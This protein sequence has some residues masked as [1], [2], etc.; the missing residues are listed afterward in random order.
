M[1]HLLMVT[2]IHT[3]NF[4]VYKAHYPSFPCFL[5]WPSTIQDGGGWGSIQKTFKQ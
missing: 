4:P 3:Q 5:A 2:Y 1:I